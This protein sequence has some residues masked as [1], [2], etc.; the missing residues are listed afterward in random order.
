VSESEESE[1]EDEEVGV[2]SEDGELE[3]AWFNALASG[4]ADSRQHTS[5]EVAKTSFR[6]VLLAAHVAHELGESG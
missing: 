4:S 5:P 6:C 1:R 2:N 3:W